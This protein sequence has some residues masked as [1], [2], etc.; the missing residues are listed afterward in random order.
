MKT[1]LIKIA[2]MLAPVVDF[3]LMFFAL[4]A[5]IV[6]AVYRRLGSR[7]LPLTTAGLKRI[8]I[9]PIRNHYYEP[10]FDDRLLTKPLNA[11]RHLPGHRL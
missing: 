1:L 11:P 3:V 7:R 4:P 6:L 9:F 2:L 5:A 8:G 10:L